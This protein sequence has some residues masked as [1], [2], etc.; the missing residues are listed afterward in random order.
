MFTDKNPTQFVISHTP[1][2]FRLQGETMGTRY[3]A[4]FYAPSN[5]DLDK[6]GRALQKA[7]DNVDNQMSPW[8]PQSDLVRFNKTPEG[9]WMDI[10]LEMAVVIREA[11]HIGRLSGGAFNIGVGE[12]VDNWGFGPSQTTS[13]ATNIAPANIIA[14]AH[15]VLELE[16]DLFRLRKHAPIVLDLCGL[17]KGF[18]VDELARVLLNFDIEDFLVSI[19]GEVKAS[20][21]KGDDTPWAIGIEK[22]DYNHRSIIQSI[23]VSDIAMATSG[24]YRHYKQVGETKVSHSMD[25]STGSPV[26]NNI[27]SVTV[28]TENCMSADALAT[29]FLVLGSENAIK[30]ANQMQ[31]SALIVER[32]LDGF[33]QLAAGEFTNLIN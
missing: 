9:Q 4:S 25:A 29:A 19:D 23:E 31:I 28:V 16:I 33:H 2:N 32:C 26:L 5:L 20:G 15:K 10:P 18:G 8:I 6:V 3:S 1:K 24:D 22:P 17:A 13:D 14:P 27:A 11:L 12:I 21:L 7:V 30:L